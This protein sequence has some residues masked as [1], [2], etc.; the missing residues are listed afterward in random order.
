MHFLPS[1]RAEELF[2]IFIDFVDRGDFLFGLWLSKGME[3]KVFSSEVRA[4]AL[5]IFKA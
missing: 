5:V 3:V 1:I 4:C 2:I